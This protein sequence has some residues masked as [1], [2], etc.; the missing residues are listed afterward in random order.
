MAHYFQTLTDEV[1]ILV[2]FGNPSW[3]T[4]ELSTTL[5]VT[6][7]YITGASINHY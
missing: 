6:P 1:D 7:S 4:Q 5:A 2:T 3:T